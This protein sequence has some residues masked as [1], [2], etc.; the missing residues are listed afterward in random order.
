MNNTF[1][2]YI[3]NYLKEKYGDCADELYSLS[4]LLQYLVNKTK[5]ANTGAKARGSF[6]N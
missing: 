6:A 5:S 4:Y 1:E 3:K 2:F